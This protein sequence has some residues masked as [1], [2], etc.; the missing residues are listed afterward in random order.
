LIALGVVSL[1]LVMASVAGGGELLDKPHGLRPLHLLQTRT[2]AHPPIATPIN[3]SQQD[4]YGDYYG[5]SP[6]QWYTGAVPA[7]R[8]GY[9]GARSS[10]TLDT[11]VGYHLDYVQWTFRR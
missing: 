3:T 11:H 8:W 5:P 10:T 6:R 2:G 9:F 7:Y 4:F 1:A